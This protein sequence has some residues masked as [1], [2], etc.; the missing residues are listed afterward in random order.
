MEHKMTYPQTQRGTALIIVLLCIALMAI[1]V[2]GY[3]TGTQTAVSRSAA[4]ASGSSARRFADSAQ[5]LALSQIKTATVG[6]TTRTWASQPGAIRTFDEAGEPESVVKLYSSD[7]MIETAENFSLESDLPPPGWEKTPGLYVDL[8]SPANGSYPII[9]PAAYTVVDG[10]EID[11]SA[12]TLTDAANSAAMPVRWIYQLQDGSLSIPTSAT[13]GETIIPN[14]SPKNL[15]VARFA[16]W[17]DDETC[18]LNINTASEGS[19]WDVPMFAGPAELYYARYQPAQKEFQRYPGHP[20]TTSLSPVLWDVF[21]LSNPNYS[22]KPALNPARNTSSYFTTKKSVAPVLETSATDYFSKLFGIIPRVVLG[23]SKMGSDATVT[24]NSVAISTVDDDR[25][26]ASVDELLFARPTD[27]AAVERPSNTPLTQEA[28]EKIRFFLTAS[29]RAPDVNLFN[30]PKIT[31]WPIDDPASANPGNLYN[32]ASD[33]RSPIDQ[34]L[35]FTST[36]HNFPYYFTRNNPLRTT[37]DFTG[38]NVVLYEYL[39]RLMQK[40]IPGFGASFSSR[41]GVAGCEQILTEIYDYIRSNINLTDSSAAGSGSS[42][43]AQLKFAFAPGTNDSLKTGRGQVVPFK[44]PTNGTKGIGRFPTIRQGMLLFTARAANQPPVKVNASLQPVDAAGNVITTAT[45]APV[46]NPLHPWIANAGVPALTVASGVPT[47]DVPNKYPTLSDPPL[48]PTQ[49]H[50]GLPYL[51]TIG[52]GGMYNQPNPRYPASLP[53]LTAHQTLVQPV[54]AFEMVNHSVGNVGLNHA[55]RV[56]VQGLNNFKAD[57]ASMGMPSDVTESSVTPRILFEK[58]YNKGLNLDYRRITGAADGDRAKPKLTF[59]GSPFIVNGTT[60]AFQGGVID[61]DVLDLNGD[62]VQTLHLDFPSTQFPTPLLPVSVP[63]RFAKFNTSVTPPVQEAAYPPAKVRDLVPS[64]L[65]TVDCGDAL[66]TSPNAGTGG[67]YY[68]SNVS[69][70][71]FPNLSTGNPD[72]NSG[73]GKNLFLP[74]RG[75]DPATDSTG[76]AKFTCDTIRSVECKYGDTRLIAALAEVPTA[77]S[78]PHKDYYDTSI[79]SA[80]CGYRG[81][82]VQPLNDVPTDYGTPTSNYFATNWGLPTG[83][84]DAMRKRLSARVDGTWRQDSLFPFTTSS[85]DFSDPNFRSLWADGGDFDTGLGIHADG[86]FINKPEEGTILYNPASPDFANPYFDSFETAFSYVGATLFSPNRQVPSPVVFGSLPAGITPASTSPS[87]PWRTLLF[88]PNPNS[89]THSSLTRNPPDYAL[90]DFFQMPV[91]EPYAISEPLSTAGKVNL[92]YQILPFTYI[93]RDTS[94]R[95]VL[96]AVDL[97]AIPDKMRYRYKS[98]FQGANRLD[99]FGD[100]NGVFDQA[101]ANS[102]YWDARYPIHAEETLKQFD[103][104]FASGEI[105]RSTS[106]ICSLWLY[107]ARQPTASDRTASGT[108]LVSYDAS[109]SSIKSWWYDDPGGNRKSLTGD[110]LR[111]RPYSLLYPRLTTKSNTYTIHVR[112]QAL[113]ARVAADGTLKESANP[114]AGEWRGSFL[115]ERYVDP[116]DPELPD[117]ADPANSDVAVDS[118]YRFRTI[119][120]KQ[121]TP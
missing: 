11:A 115:V 64:T 67:N 29:S 46:I 53:A 35:A 120:T 92:N 114:V 51:T 71:V 112:S 81:G 106:E 69:R 113:K 21:G 68:E 57:G 44:H 98:Q 65:L 100:A 119:S 110:N 84:T 32:T 101:S 83:G 25:L 18:K 9:N 24:G 95:G 12:E 36:L 118:F 103:A 109:G 23:G 62:V 13:G 47:I 27:P 87:A 1:L 91:V 73:P 4:Y 116:N 75:A 89:P 74:E 41:Y 86:P 85:T 105:F 8:N 14:A 33:S 93:R 55:F 102:G 30:Q 49:T 104:K 61:I 56:R 94:L 99:F 82:T 5:A 70:L 77:F 43:A 78:V 15:P 48:A 2:A 26:F 28:L 34:L 19:Y 97:T 79:R 38:R 6:G 31:I 117:F 10:F 76:R 7:K 50:A 45:Q 80:Q 96:K 111:E 60:F 63:G 121:L 52:A 3:L 42:E 20:A 16:F 40:P 66:G 17:T 90:L 107:P 22:L 72:P 37:A 108:A 54:F 39:S 58:E 59:A 88:S